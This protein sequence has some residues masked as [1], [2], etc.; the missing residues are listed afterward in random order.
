MCGII[1]EYRFDSKQID[2]KE[3]DKKLESPAGFNCPFPAIS[4]GQL[5]KLIGGPAAGLKKTN[6]FTRTYIF[7]L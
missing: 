5:F 3:F 1:G 6:L 4:A 7:S 2:R